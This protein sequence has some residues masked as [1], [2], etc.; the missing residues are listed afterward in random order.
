[1]ADTPFVSIVIPTHARP[2][3]LMRAIESCLGDIAP[4]PVEVIVVANGGGSLPE[5]LGHYPAVRVIELT[6]ANGNAARNAGLAVARGHFVRFL[7]D[8]DYLLTKG[9]GAQHRIAAKTNPDVCSGAILL[10]DDAGKEFQRIAPTAGDDFARAM[11]SPKCT[12][13]PTAHLF[14]RKFLENLEWNPTQPHLQ[15]VAWIHGILRRSEVKWVA[16]DTLV[17]VWQHHAQKRVSTGNLKQFPDMAL[18][19]IAGITIDTIDTLSS[20][21]R[22]PD[23][24]KVV[25]AEALWHYAHQGFPL[26]PFYWARVAKSAMELDPLSRPE[27]DFYRRSPW[28]HLHPLLLECLLTPKRRLNF[29][30][31]R[32][33]DRSVRAG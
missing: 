32:F 15:D 22:L 25:A 33:R 28:R 3:L 13:Q 18:R 29:H 19:E 12:T 4:G 9:A 8:D 5:A 6:V 14:R 17:G 16:T 1:M 24:R 2:Q 23:S 27:P 26:A 31:R 11:L 10:L 7:D 20:Q 21:G 30:L